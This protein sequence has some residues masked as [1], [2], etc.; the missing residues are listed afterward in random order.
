L[1]LALQLA[2]DPGY[3]LIAYG[4]WTFETS[5]FALLVLI[6]VI[7]LVLRLTYLLLAW[8]NPARFFRKTDKQTTATK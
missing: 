4:S 7:T 5:V 2:N 3:V 1:F 6:V 8:L